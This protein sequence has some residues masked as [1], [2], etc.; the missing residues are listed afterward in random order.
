[1]HDAGH[2]SLQVLL[3][4]PRLLV[5]DG[6]QKLGG[7]A[8]VTVRAVDVG[9]ATLDHVTHGFI[10]KFVTDTIGQ[11]QNSLLSVRLKIKYVIQNYHHS[12]KRFSTNK[13]CSAFIL[14]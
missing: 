4:K 3:V 10:P 7:Q 8:V 11:E 1:V 13:I 9:Q 6:G 2:D 5:R 14:I 12:V